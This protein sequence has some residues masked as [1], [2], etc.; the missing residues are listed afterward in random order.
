MNALNSKTFT[1]QPQ[2][3]GDLQEPITI[4]TVCDNDYTLL[5]AAL[6]KSI[7][8]NLKKQQR[9]NLYVVGDGVSE[10]NKRKLLKSVNPAIFSLTWLNI[11]ESIPE[12]AHIPLDHSTF[13]KTVYVRLFIPYFVDQGIDKVL[14]LDVDMIVVEDISKLWQIDIGDKI[15]AGVVDRAEL[16][17]NRWSGIANYAELNIAR[18]TK[19]FNSGLIVLKPKEWRE[20]EIAAK[21][22]K[23]T[24][25]NAQYAVFADQYGLNVV[26]A[27]QWFELDSKWNCFATLDEKNPYIIH[28]IGTKPIYKSYNAN[29]AY[30]EEFYKY[31]RLTEWRN[32]KPISD[33]YR[34]LKK[35]NNKVGKKV[36]SFFKLE[37]AN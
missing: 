5:L 36:K 6:L 32:H 16:I 7:E 4:V 34:I 8:I 25:E 13:P 20:R 11:E 9:I 21:V 28:F 27:N 18:D 17:G 30:K 15:V 1:D 12:G 10:K 29:E 22:V 2:G 31:L 35:F 26:L 3:N 33:Y 19:L 23:C 24:E 14:Y 37:A